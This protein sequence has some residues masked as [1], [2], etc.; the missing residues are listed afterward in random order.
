[1]NKNQEYIAVVFAFVVGFAF[2]LSFTLTVR[3]Q[4]VEIIEFVITPIPTATPHVCP[5][6]PEPC[7]KVYYKELPDVNRTLSSLSLADYELALVD[8]KLENYI[9]STEGEYDWT[10][11]S[12]LALHRSAH[13]YLLEASEDIIGWSV[14]GE[15]TCPQ[16]TD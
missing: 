8:A 4:R 13:N 7:P 10:L 11:M 3:P 15:L 5:P 2:G 16:T 6:L 1:M 9:T 14:L 12:I